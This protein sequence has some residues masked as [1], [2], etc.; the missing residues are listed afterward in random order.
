MDIKVSIWKYLLLGELV[1]VIS[2]EEIGNDIG[3][4]LGE[5]VEP[6]NA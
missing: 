1:G 2:S 5:G 4:F 6:K 3:A